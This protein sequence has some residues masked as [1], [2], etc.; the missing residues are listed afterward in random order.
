MQVK[1]GSEY[2]FCAK[3][4]NLRNCCFAVTPKIDIKFSVPGNDLL[5]LSIDD[6]SLPLECDF[7]RQIEKRFMVPT[8]TSSVSDPWIRAG[9]RPT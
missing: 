5:G 7:W 3:V 1:S 2:K 6:A 8:G 9:T 4:F